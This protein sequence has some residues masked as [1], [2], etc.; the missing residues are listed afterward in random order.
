[1][2]PFHLAWNSIHAVE[3][4]FK[5][6]LKEYTWCMVKKWV[7]CGRIKAR[8]RL[9]Q[10][11]TLRTKRSERKTN[12]SFP[13]SAEVMDEWRYATTVTHKVCNM[14]N[15]G[16]FVRLTELHVLLFSQILFV[17][18]NCRILGPPYWY[19]Q[20]NTHNSTFCPH[21]VFMFCV[22]LRTNSDYFTVQH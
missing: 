7:S 8:V 5:M 6:L 3:V 13:S 17:R 19:H 10:F 20:F 18:C 22:D 4:G 21:S 14:L 2:N 16:L 11:I 9:E 15:V 1:M 12:H